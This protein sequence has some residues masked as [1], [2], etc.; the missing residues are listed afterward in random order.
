MSSKR[1]GNRIEKQNTFVGALLLGVAMSLAGA[2]KV[3]LAAPLVVDFKQAAN[4]DAPA[5][6]SL[7]DVHWINSIVQAGNAMYFE[8]MSNPQR[9][10]F[11][12]IAATTGNIHSLSLS[13]QATKGGIHAYDFL[14]SWVQ[15][16]AAAD[17]IV[18]PPPG[19][20]TGDN[21]PIS[22]FYLDD[23]CDESIGPPASLGAT[24][25]ALDSGGF[26]VD[27]PV[28]DD[29]FVSKDGSTQSRIDAYE[30]A[31]GNRT[32]RI[33]GNAAISAASLTLC[34]H[35]VANG[36][37]TGDSYINYI[38][39]WTSSSTQILIQAAGHLGVSGDPN[40]D[41]IAWGPT[42]GS[43][44]ING[45]PYHF[46]LK[47][48]GSTFTAAPACVQS[49]VA[50]LGSQDNQIK[51]ADI[52]VPCPTCLV[53][54]PS[55]VCPGR[56][57]PYTVA[58]TGTAT[59]PVY[60]WTVTTGCSIV[61]PN[62]GS[63][64]SVQA[65][66]NC[67]TCGVCVS[68]TSD[69]CPDGIGCCQTVSIEDTTDPTIGTPGAEGTIQ[70]P[71]AP[72]FTP[73]TAG[74]ACDPNPD[75]NEV[76]DVTTPGVCPG[77]YD[78]TKCWNAVDTCG[79]DS[80]S[81]CQTIHVVDTT[82]PTLGNPGAEGTIQCPAA[83]V[84]T[85]PTA[86]DT[87]DP[88][89]D[90]IEVSD[91]TTPGSCPG[92]YDRTKCWEAEDCSG[93]RSAQK[94]QTIHV[95][96]TTVPTLGNPGA[97][98]T[99]QCPA[100]PV[101]TPPTAGD[102]CDPSPDVI[103]VSDV[104]TPGS[105]PG[106]YDRT[107]C[108]KAEDCSGN[109]SAQKCQTIH[110]VD[111]TDPTIGSS[112]PDD[113]IECPAAPV[114]TPPTAGDTCD[115]SPDV[116]E[117][118]DV[119]T[120]GSCPGTYDRTKCWKAEDCS[121]NRS[122]QKC[123]TIHVV[124]T[125][126]PTIGS[127]GPDDTIE[128]PAV[129]VFAPPTASDTCDPDPDVVEVSDVTTP[130]ACAGT[131]SRTKCWKAVDCAGNESGLECQTI[132]VVDT[133]PPEVTCPADCTLECG[134]V[135]VPPLCA[136]LSCDCGG[137]ATCNDD[138]TGPC[139]VSVTCEVIPDD[140]LVG[141]VAGV[142]V[143]PKVT[144][145]RTFTGTDTTT[146]TAGDT[147]GNTASC[148]QKIEIVDTTPPVLGDCPPDIE[149]CYGDPVVFTP[150]G[151]SDTCGECTVDCTR[152]DGLTLADA[153]PVGS[154][155]T[156]T[157][158]ATDDCGNESLPCTTDVTVNANPECDVTG[159]D[160][161]HHQTSGIISGGS[162]PYTC[163]DPLPGVVGT[164]WSVVDCDVTG[165][166][167]AVTYAVVQ[168]A[169]VAVHFDVTVV[170]AN[171]CETT[172]AD[173]IDRTVECI[174]DPP[175]QGVCRGEGAQQFCATAVSGYPPFT[176]AW[177]GPG[178][179]TADTECVTPPTEIGGEFCVVLTDIDGFQSVPCCAIL[180]VNPNPTCTITGDTSICVQ[181]QTEFCS[182]PSGGTGPY[183]FLWSTGATTPCITTGAAG[184]Y[185]VT[186]TDS[187]DCSGSCEQTLTLENCEA[188]RMTGGGHDCFDGVMRDDCSGAAGQQKK[189]AGTDIY[190]FGGQAG[191]PTASLPEPS[192]EWTHVQHDG[193]DGKWTFHA[194]THSAPPETVL[195]LIEC[196]D[197]GFCHPARPAP[198]KQIDFQGTGSFRNIISNP[199][200]SLAGA[201]PGNGGTFHYFEVHVED[202][203]EPGNNGNQPRAGRDCP[204]IGSAGFLADCACPDFY[205]LRIHATAAP[206]SA[207]VY[208]V[209]GYLTGGNLQ[210]HPPIR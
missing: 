34:G 173:D 50:S 117:V 206:A 113:T 102:T 92:V 120:P 82:A 63:S 51:G 190:T 182:V 43:G 9:V 129:P 116:I 193:P 146:T 47:D 13:H 169:S 23:Q 184:T 118:S 114:F 124:D 195:A 21:A 96:D 67:G 6:L 139:T 183:T 24:C 72:V 97:E 26:C 78:R 159:L 56:T 153:Y 15:A 45:G 100:A 3:A 210:I 160:V 1:S 33:C 149:V 31:F 172:C 69:N 164:G 178:G 199:N 12:N 90:V 196:S 86:G 106:T 203:G 65:D 141:A 104:T 4:D 107:K 136:D 158:I 52:L 54:G 11:S 75:V 148:T 40:I 112:G 64:V 125:T 191:A 130:G 157:C 145:L 91:V 208:E 8:G 14:T 81:A 123:Q 80:A 89:P 41:A 18:A 151:C 2:P 76:S 131:Y 188:C 98:G 60:N 155:V 201:I 142:A 79:N 179:F 88:N 25:S 162:S 7:G 192:G 127:S 95:V 103:E 122:A 185:T 71:A 32:I 61:G 198:A 87:C 174:V 74:D 57:N 194:G 163:H 55:P 42:V 19:L 77:V 187:K 119:T 126:D 152:S 109:S 115:P 138:C 93:N 170:D 29:P 202:L 143:P 59:N 53:S 110:V 197:P 161:P 140:C 147:C 186:V 70:C 156:I 44:Q 30:S 73:P 166:T 94:C 171:G 132:D 134:V 62:T 84:F 128:C 28:P 175:S 17:A 101:F 168:P 204:R 58:V 200:G 135:C 133:V 39:A 20:L 209:W 154:T 49:D 68:I 66:N 180:V 46:K 99:I 181:D 105:C 108:W 38:F 165:A 22:P 207:V 36:A 167:F 5:P 189:Q 27:V 137:E 35:D 144:V 111:T 176:Y 121:G 85:P 10:V 48:L 150:P 205:H 37:D 83:P 177:T 16:V